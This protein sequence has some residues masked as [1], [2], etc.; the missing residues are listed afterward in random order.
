[1]SVQLIEIV[2][3]RIERHAKAL[4]RVDEAH[5]RTGCEG[6]DG[7]GNPLVL[8]EIDYGEIPKPAQNGS[9]GGIL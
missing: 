9:V 3:I 1:M 5:A 7:T 4:H 8:F 2:D 6:E